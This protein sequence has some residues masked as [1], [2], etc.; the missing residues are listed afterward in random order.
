MFVPR[1]V[2]STELRVRLQELLC[3][4][5]DATFGDFNTYLSES[6]LARIQFILRFN[7][8]QPVE[9]DIKRLEEKL[10][11]LARNWRDDLLNAS[12]EASG[13]RM[14]TC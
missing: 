6:V 10:V 9:Y 2:F 1:D 8:D 14:P 12:I 13:R 5:L 11:K 7:G 3:E 4:E